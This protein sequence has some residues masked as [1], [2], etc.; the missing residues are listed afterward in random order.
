MRDL[1]NLLDTVI[2]EATIRKYGPGTLFIVSDAKDGL[3]VK[4]SLQAQGIDAES[5]MEYIDWATVDTSQLAGIVGKTDLD[6][7]KEYFAFK[8]TTGQ[9]WVYNAGESTI[10]SSFNHY[11]GG[12]AGGELKIA[13]RGETAEGILGAA[14]FAKFTKR[15]GHEDLGMVTVGDVVSVLDKLKNI[16]EDLYQVVVNDADNK[17]ADTVNFLLKLKTNPYRDLMDPAKRELLAKDFA[18]AVGYVN[19]PMAERYSK[20]FYLNGK[21][22]ELAV[23]ADGAASETERK[24][25]VWVAV[26]DDN[27]N[28]RQLK[29][30]TS[31]KVGGVAQF[32]QVGGSSAES[33]IKL[34]NYFG[35]DV[36][37]YVKSYESKMK[38]D[39]FAAIE[40]MYRTIAKHIAKELAGDSDLEEARFVD[41]I[42]HAV[43][44]FATLG[45]E[46]VELV[47]FDKGG[48]KILR[49]KNLVEKMRNVNLTASYLDKKKRPEISIHDIDNPK[50]ELV[51]VRSK[52]ETRPDGSLY[53]RNIIEKGPLLE[54]ITKV[55]ERAWKELEMPDP[56]S[57]RVQIRHPGSARKPRGEKGLGR[58]R[59]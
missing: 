18:S 22:D 57:T 5:P 27:G 49:F 3:K 32:G 42:A 23:I 50:K 51:N 52:I 17:H 28:M 10:N 56:E 48:F 11:K 6:P 54:Q 36:T 34:W 30:N 14:M 19:S 55:Q 7:N 4:A 26:K 8:T 41:N 40:Y 12:K 24:T 31:L 59:R 29:L 15:E 53:V 1:L 25:D 37:P 13:N 9:I 35:I 39:Q 38:K 46:N 44:F 2:T 43:T 33:M 47:D 21:A 20:Y 58:E 16:G 45:D